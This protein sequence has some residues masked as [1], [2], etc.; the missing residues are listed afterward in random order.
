MILERCYFQEEFSLIVF[1]VANLI[2]F[3]V[4]KD[5]TDSTDNL[6][7][8]V[9]EVNETPHSAFVR[10]REFSDWLPLEN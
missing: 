5:S 4:G 1:V 2:D 9:C 3:K 7:K 10:V 8:V 6:F